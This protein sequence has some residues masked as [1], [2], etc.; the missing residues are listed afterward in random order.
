[1][2]LWLL[3]HCPLLTLRS[4]APA[5]AAAAG[6]PEAHIHSGESAVIVPRLVAGLG[7]R[8][9]VAVAAA[10]HHTVLATAAGEVLTMGSNRHGQLGYPSGDT[11]PTPRR[12]AALRQ[13]IVAVAAGNKCALRV[14]LGGLLGVLPLG[15]LPPGF[16]LGIPALWDRAA[17]CLER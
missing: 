12:V 1:M 5:A 15:V 16:F 9:V 17:A 11:Q 14:L 4:R 8:E 7:R 6:H 3:L 2:M 10:K 13:R